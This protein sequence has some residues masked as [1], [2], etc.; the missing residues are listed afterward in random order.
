MFP[1]GIAD[2]LGNRFEAKWAVQKLMEVFLGDAGSLRFESIDPVD[3][4]VE[5]SLVR[6]NHKE[7][8][9]TKRQEA[10]G[11]WTVRRL[12]KEAVLDAAL[13]KITAGNDQLFVFI[14]EDPAKGLQGLSGKAAIARTVQQFEDNLS[15]EQKKE[16]IALNG[17]WETSTEQSW[18]YLLRCRFEVV[19]ET[20]IDD[21]VRVLAAL[22]FNEPANTVFPVLR[23][24]LES[25]LNRE[26]TTEAVRKELTENL[27][28]TPRSVFDPTLCERLALATQRYLESYIPFGAGGES[29]P[30]KETHEA[31]DLLSKE[32]GPRI[33]L[34]T[35]IAGAGKSGVVRAIIGEL[36]EKDITHLAFRVDRN[37]DIKSAAE[38]GKTLFGQEEEPVVTL[39]ALG[40]H[41]QS[42]LVIDQ[43]DA[44]SEASGR[45]GS[46]RDVVLELIRL[47]QVADGV[48]VLVVCRSFDLT[49]DS[50]LRSLEQK[51]QVRRIELTPLDW[52]EGVKPFLLKRGFHTEHL[53]PGQQTLLSLPLNLTLFLDVVTPSDTTISFSSTSELFD[54][55]MERKQRA[56]RDRG[57]HELSVAEVL[58]KLANAMSEDQLLDAPQ[59]VLDSF[60]N[61]M[62][63]LLSESLIIRNG[64]RIAFFHESF[65]DYVFARSFVTER[66]HILDF[67][68]S[69]EQF[70]FRRTQVRQILTAYRQ[71]GSHSRYLAELK[72]LLTSPDVR[73]HLK[74]SASR[75]LG[76]IKEPSEGELDIVLSLDNSSGG[77][78]VL[79]RLALY[80]SNWFSLLLHRGL[81]AIWLQAG[82]VE[83]CRDALQIL[84]NA[85]AKY[86][87]DVSDT[88]RTWWSGDGERGRELLH[89]FFGLAEMQP[90]PELVNLNLDL[91][92][93]RP[94]D[95]F[96][97]GNHFDF[98]VSWIKNAPSAAGDI[99]RVWFETWFAAFPDDHPFKRDYQ[100]D[101]D[102]HWLNELRE[103]CPTAFLDA[104]VPAFAEAIR[105]IN[106][107]YDGEQ[108]TDY[109]WYSRHEGNCYGAS[110]F[111]SLLRSALTEI[112]KNDPNR[113]E[114]YLQLI[115]PAAHPA[116][117]YLHLE[118]ITANGAGLGDLLMGLC[119]NEDIFKAG[120]RRAEWFSFAHAAK[121]SLPFLGEVDRTIVE[122]CILNYWSELPYAKRAA[123]LLASGHPEDE[124][125]NRTYVISKLNSNGYEQWC[126]LKTI[127]PAQLSAKAVERLAMLERKFQ[128]ESV[129]EPLNIEARWVPPPI[130]EQSAKFMS[131]RSWLRAMSKY[132]DDR[133]SQRQ[134]GQWWS[135]SGVRGL[136]QV[137]QERTKEEPERFARLLFRLP[138][139]VVLDYPTAI[140]RGLAE[141]QVALDILQKT[142]HYAHS[143]PGRPF[144]HGISRIFQS[145]PELAEDEQAFEILA[146]YVENGI[147]TTEGETDKKRVEQEIV[148]VNQL[149]RRGGGIQIR[150]TYD[151]RGAAAEALAVVLWNCPSRLE[152]G[153]A[154]LERRVAIE[155]LQSIRCCLMQPIYSVFR[156]D[157]KR[158]AKLLYDL[159]VRVDGADLTPLSTNHGVNA[160]FYVLH[161]SPEVGYDLLDRL[162]LSDEEDQH[163]IGA[164]HLFREAFYDAELAARA[165]EL[166]SKGEIYRK[167]AADAAANHLPHAD[168][169]ERAER[170]LEIFFDDPIKEIR[171]EAASCFRNIKDEDLNFYRPLLRK[172]I[173]SRVFEDENFSFFHLL[174]ET[175]EHTFEE[176][177][178]SSERLLQLSD[179]K[180]KEGNSFREMHY[181]D[182][183][184][185]R[186][187][188]AVTDRPDL[189]RRLLDVIDRMLELNLYGT[190]QI[191]KEHERG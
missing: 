59:S 13:S 129:A 149:T 190:E 128:G 81:L 34:L 135:H 119:N 46:M 178:L 170:Q 184:I 23:N 144:C 6:S 49:S 14:S 70:L 141:S 158:A 16:L 181:L 123:H 137:L 18:Q 30:R 189:R 17:V 99:L 33:V 173:Q 98:L 187:Y 73:Y 78:P 60:P 64:N 56:I 35:G 155:P 133:D 143:Q 111:L 103:K 69:D 174:K 115:D 12:K 74:D 95:I 63:L 145:Q 75:W 10:K 162:L 191:I 100:S 188:T 150:G 147:A 108:R 122:D 120:P 139:D 186:E 96:H 15:D 165:D 134:K 176:V 167:L 131:D 168:Y 85:A 164:F 67:L 2:K 51:E 130:G 5:F 31:I 50:A 47:A 43:V 110:L 24:Y 42:V 40:R 116:A 71:S 68:K 86:P 182:D 160:L 105:R 140:L 177:I 172:F 72:A 52:E 83:R 22:A 36:K 58:S 44:V 163:L 161:G 169:R 45:V 65:F 37:L 153:I 54:L 152:K 4:G 175:R 166:I 109:T 127:G 20:S 179:I 142:I 3:H 101:I 185:I 26:L 94:T 114:E 53:T 148:D 11:N 138:P 21:H 7:W 125:Y 117:L 171:V 180:T 93:S 8:H 61:A 92:R 121:S 66:R 91:I 38:L 97:D 77:L 82:N 107:S 118:T 126:I 32:D 159:V 57:H 106:R 154:I 90:A 112:A 89:W 19:S 27:G 102:H 183:L 25:N 157:V 29:I 28:L 136:S 62:D 151:D 79:V 80:H 156:H 146:W 55:L 76:T 84:R 1:G 48:R 88:L 113:A 87:S 104:T 41:K 132:H 9:Q 124:H 39:T